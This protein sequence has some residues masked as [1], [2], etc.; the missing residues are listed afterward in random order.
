MTLDDIGNYLRLTVE[1]ISCM[2][3]RF[4]KT[5]TL[6]VKCKYITINDMYKLTEIAGKTST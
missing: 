6:S 5:N 1:T 4:Q 2:L 3:G